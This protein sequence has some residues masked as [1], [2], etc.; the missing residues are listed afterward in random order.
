MLPA[1]AVV[2]TN[3]GCVQQGILS[4]IYS[5]VPGYQNLVVLVISYPGK[6]PVTYLGR[7]PGTYSGRCTRVGTRVGTP[8]VIT[9]PTEHILGR[10]YSRPTMVELRVAYTPQIVAGHEIQ[11]ADGIVSCLLVFSPQEIWRCF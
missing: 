11:F 5:G 2:V 8:R 1:A 6:Y 7:Y 9:Y 4:N 3:H 10:T